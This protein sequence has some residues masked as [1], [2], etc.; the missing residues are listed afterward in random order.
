MTELKTC[1]DQAAE[2]STSYYLLGFYV[3]QRTASWAGTSWK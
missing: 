3:A 1:I 2:D